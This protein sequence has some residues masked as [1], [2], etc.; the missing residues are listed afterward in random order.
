MI[1]MQNFHY[2]NELCSV[3]YLLSVLFLS[4]FV[5]FFLDRR[6]GGGALLQNRCTMVAISLFG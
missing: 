1:Q 6:G 5:F 3:Q 2:V 4:W